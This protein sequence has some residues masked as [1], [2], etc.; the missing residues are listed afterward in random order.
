[1]STWRNIIKRLRKI[2]G[3]KEEDKTGDNRSCEETDEE[4]PEMK[5]SF[6]AFRGI[7]GKRRP[8]RVTFSLEVETFEI[9]GRREENY[10]LRHLEYHY[11]GGARPKVR[12]DVEGRIPTQE[13]MSIWFVPVYNEE[14]KNEDLSTKD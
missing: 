5:R 7:K 10:N 8:K 2:F 6:D 1:M 9:P 11:R 3:N 12:E 13:E 14:E 4:L